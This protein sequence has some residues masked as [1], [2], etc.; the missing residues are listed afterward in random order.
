MYETLK[1]YDEIIRN[2]FKT[3]IYLKNKLNNNVL[4][5]DKAKELN[6]ILEMLEIK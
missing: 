4:E 3:V 1:L 5:Y 6:N 2:Y